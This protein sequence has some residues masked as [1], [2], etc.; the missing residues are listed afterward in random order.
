TQSAMWL[1]RP[2]PAD[3]RHA[4]YRGFNAIYAR[5]ERSYAA[6]IAGM[7]ARSVIMVAIALAIIIGA[8]YGFSGVATGFLP[9][10]D[11]RYLLASVQLP[12]GAS[13]G[14]T[15]KVLDEVARIA[16]RTSGV[17]QVVT[18]AGVSA[19]DNNATLANGGVAYIILKPWSERGS[20]EDLRSLFL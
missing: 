17:Q 3:Q 16:R 19:L 9:I 15:Q 5:L 20:G 7:V 14:R 1:R 18:I 11:Q 4:F 10:E 8:G 6:L 2:V 12:D 13:L